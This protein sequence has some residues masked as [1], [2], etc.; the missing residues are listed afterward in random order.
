[1]VHGRHLRRIST[2]AWAG[3]TG[4]DIQRAENIYSTDLF[5]PLI[6]SAAAIADSDYGK[7]AATEHYV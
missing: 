1:M 2:R 3:T 7:D 4:G 6:A 5:Q